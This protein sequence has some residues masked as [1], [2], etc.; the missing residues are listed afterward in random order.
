MLK[1]EPLRGKVADEAVNRLVATL[2]DADA[3]VIFEGLPHQSHQRAQLKDEIARKKNV[4]LFDFHFYE[5]PTELLPESRRELLAI[6]QEKPWFDPEPEGNARM[7]KKCGGFHPDYQVEW[8]TAGKVVQVQFCLGCD[9]VMIFT[10]DQR[11]NGGLLKSERLTAWLRGFCK[12]RPADRDSWSQD[13][14]SAK[15]KM[16]QLDRLLKQFSNGETMLWEGLPSIRRETES[17]DAEC[18]TKHPAD[19]HGYFY[20]EP[21]QTMRVGL[22]DKFV[23]AVLQKDSLK[24]AW[25]PPQEVALYFPQGDFLIRWKTPEGELDT[26][27]D[28]NREEIH[29]YWNDDYG[30]AALSKDALAK[31]KALLG[32]FHKQ[33]PA[34]KASLVS[35]PV[36][37][38]PPTPPKDPSAVQVPGL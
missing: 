7:H 36:E 5:Q 12:L 21:S 2:K 28:F 38:T 18:D 37:I 23:D 24:A 4:V 15:A 10:E 32:E 16:A 11:I 6:L 9:D 25:P 30:F 33:R 20:Y 29:Y 17:Y 22:R 19:I 31:L 27:V 1:S 34:F 3:A 8:K 26:Q 13:E 14:E 35:K